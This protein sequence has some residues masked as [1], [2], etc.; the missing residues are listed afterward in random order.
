MIN[1]T[2]SNQYK[3][4]RTATSKTKLIKNIITS[5]LI[6]IILSILINQ[7]IIVPEYNSS[8]SMIISESE[9]EENNK[10]NNKMFYGILAN[11]SLIST[12]SE[13][14]RSR[15][16]LNQVIDNLEL[17]MDYNSLSNKI[18]V[19]PIKDTQ[20]MSITVLDNNPIRAKDIANET[21]NIFKKSISEIIKVDNV[22]ILDGATIAE[23][24][25]FPNI[26]RN[27]SFW[28]YI[29]AI[30]GFFIT[31]YQN[32]KEIINSS[33]DIKYYFGI[34]VLGNIPDSKQ[35][36]SNNRFKLF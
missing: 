2:N 25:I 28:L 8:V 6:F 19:R 16:V 33:D 32:S 21:A 9:N 31:N 18:T 4:S 15:G 3:K 23:K 34:P 36:Y 20:I 10:N 22:K 35:K 24:P 12:Y 13:I 29:G 26:G 5:S 17:D 11:K 14:V 30:I 27:I 7:F 1:Y